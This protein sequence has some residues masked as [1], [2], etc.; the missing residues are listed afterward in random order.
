MCKRKCPGWDSNPHCTDFEA[1]SSTNWDT[2]ASPLCYMHQPVPSHDDKGTHYPIAVIFAKQ[3]AAAAQPQ[4]AQT[5]HGNHGKT[6]ES[7]N[8]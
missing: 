1:V 3:N 4:A 5:T 8:L 6:G 7:G 2:G